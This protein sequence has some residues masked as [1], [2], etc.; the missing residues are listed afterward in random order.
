M[1][2]MPSPSS[3][4]ME[5]SMPYKQHQPSPMAPKT[6]NTPSSDL[7]PT[8]WT[9]NAPKVLMPGPDYGESMDFLMNFYAIDPNHPAAQQH[10]LQAQQQHY[11]SAHAQQIHAASTSS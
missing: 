11:A 6:P 1:Q 2:H 10:L 8:P 9:E 5:Y 4:S 7:Q 3:A